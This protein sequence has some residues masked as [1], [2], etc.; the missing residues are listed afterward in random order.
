MQPDPPQPGNPPY[1]PPPMAGGPVPWSGGP[2]PWAATTKP[3]ANTAAAVTAGVLALLTAVMLVWFALY[4]VVYAGGP[5]SGRWSSLVLENA[6]GGIA[7]AGLLLVAA[8]FTVA[9]KIPGA[10]ALCALCVLY[11]VATLF[12]GPLLRGTGLG[13]QFR[14]VFG[15]DRGDGVGV[16]LAMIFGVLTAIAAAIAG[17]VKSYGPAPAMPPRP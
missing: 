15:F 5:S 11:V 7:G 3:R 14:F 17:S 9:R 16:A 8:A 1:G 13:A 6:I 10:W 4:N 12:V 2:G